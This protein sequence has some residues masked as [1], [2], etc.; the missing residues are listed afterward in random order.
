M[1]QDEV[2]TAEAWLRRNKFAESIR[3]GREIL[4]NEIRKLSRGNTILLAFRRRYLKTELFP[5]NVDCFYYRFIGHGI[6]CF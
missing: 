3:A 2:A 1:R 5:A 4:G 6:S